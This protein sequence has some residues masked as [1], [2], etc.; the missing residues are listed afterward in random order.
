M[1]EKQKENKKGSADDCCH[2][3]NIHNLRIQTTM[4]LL[5]EE[6][7]QTTSSNVLNDMVIYN[8]PNSVLI[9]T[10]PTVGELS[11]SHKVLLVFLRH[12]QCIFW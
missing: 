11:K 8:F 1:L 6:E 4:S 2:L 12:F 3:M 9:K 5:I 7:P 10:T